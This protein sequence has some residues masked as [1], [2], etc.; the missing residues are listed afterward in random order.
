MSRHASA[1]ELASLDLDGLKPRKAAR[2]EAHVGGCVRCTQLSSEISAVPT[3]LASVPYPAMPASLSAQIDTALASESARRLAS[4]PASEAGRRDLPERSSRRARTQRA[5]WHLPRLSVV[6][7]RIAA[8]ASALVIVGVGGYEIASHVGSNTQRTAASSSGSVAAP[9]ALAGRMNFGPDIRYGAPASTKSIRTM[10]SDI[11]F[12]SAG[13][14]A[15]ALAAVQAAA[16]RGDLGAQA[17]VGPAPNAGA[18]PA[19]GNPSGS[20]AQSDPQLASCV[21]GLVGNQTVL[22]VEQAKY[23]GS[24]AIII[25]AAQTPNRGAEVWVVGPTCSASHPD[26]LHHLM[27]SST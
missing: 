6:T 21:D 5:G 7:T 16:V 3:T 20:S 2:I 9:N 19:Q 14:G 25:V 26:V 18:K 12:T 23:D 17:T 24:P 22:L 8:V 13:L 11:N 1:E 27:L 4:A 10:T 15:Q